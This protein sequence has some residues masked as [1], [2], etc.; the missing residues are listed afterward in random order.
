MSDFGTVSV[1]RFTY[2]LGDSSLIR[3]LGISIDCL[4]VEGRG[5]LIVLA[6][7]EPVSWVWGRAGIGGED[8][9]RVMDKRWRRGGFVEARGRDFV[10]SRG[11]E[12][13]RSVTGWGGIEEKLTEGMRCV[14]L[15]AEDGAPAVD[16]RPG[17]RAISD[18]L[19]GVQRDGPWAEDGRVPGD[20]RSEWLR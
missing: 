15:E 20:V 14:D 16:G 3:G 9:K 2:C 4:D 8:G 18:D 13:I 1:R 5:E 7:G 6:S 12:S 19:K 11:N 10:G 17:R